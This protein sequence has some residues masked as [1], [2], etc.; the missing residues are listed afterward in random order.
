LEIRNVDVIMGRTAKLNARAKV[1]MR[2][3]GRIEALKK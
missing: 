1:K 3:K 2:I